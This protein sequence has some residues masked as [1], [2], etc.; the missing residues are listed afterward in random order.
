MSVVQTWLC[1]FNW[2]EKKNF[3]VDIL[4]SMSMVEMSLNCLLSIMTLIKVN[5]NKWYFYCNFLARIT[6]KNENKE[7]I[8]WEK[9]GMKITSSNEYGQILRVTQRLIQYEKMCT[10]L[11][12]MWF[13]WERERKTFYYYLLESSLFSFFFFN[14][15]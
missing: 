2:V 6:H 15:L 12:S 4:N 9:N 5:I 13:L 14:N 11:E 7:D 8:C 3:A 10:S 1:I